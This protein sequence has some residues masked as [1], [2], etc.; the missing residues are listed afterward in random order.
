MP[1]RL[2]LSNRVI[3]TTQPALSGHTYAC[4]ELDP[5]P[6]QAA[7]WLSYWLGSSGQREVNCCVSGWATAPARQQQPPLQTSALKLYP[8]R[9][10]PAPAA[11]SNRLT[12]EGCNPATLSE[13]QGKV[14]SR[15]HKVLFCVC[16]LSL[17]TKVWLQICTC[18]WRADAKYSCP[19]WHWHL[20]LQKAWWASRLNQPLRRPVP[21]SVPFRFYFCLFFLLP[22]I[23]RRKKLK[24]RNGQ[25]GITK[26]KDHCPLSM[27]WHNR[28]NGFFGFFRIFL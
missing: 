18:V 17:L 19:F 11:C 12:P 23:P 9:S 10:M 27:S 2:T 24:G 8:P 3:P 20:Q 26:E 28:S 21:F 6:A 7:S 22:I 1:L 15:T 13:Y 25:K 5:T 14:Y 4:E 16:R